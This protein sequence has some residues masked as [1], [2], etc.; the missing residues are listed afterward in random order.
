MLQSYIDDK[1]FEEVKKK[2]GELH[3]KMLK[4]IVKRFPGFCKNLENLISNFYEDLD[5]E[6][7]K[8][9]KKETHKKLERMNNDIEMRTKRN[10]NNEIT[11]ILNSIIWSNKNHDLF[12]SIRKYMTSVYYITGNE[13]KF[14]VYDMIDHSITARNSSQRTNTM[15]FLQRYLYISLCDELKLKESKY[16]ILVDTVLYL[17][18]FN[19]RYVRG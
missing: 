4:D 13:L 9:L 6:K 14:E 16:K 5:S 15:V 3:S 12:L 11:E 18:H 17:I 1:G 10:A 7:F 8:E 19:E 2:L